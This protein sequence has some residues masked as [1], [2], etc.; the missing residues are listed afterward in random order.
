MGNF[1]HI[2]GFNKQQP[3]APNLSIHFEKLITI[4]FFSVNIKKNGD[5]QSWI[6]PFYLVLGEG[7]NRTGKNI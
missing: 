6:N 7:W 1:G 3:L 4:L 2:W 5:G